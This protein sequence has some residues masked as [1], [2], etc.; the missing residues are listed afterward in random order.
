[1]KY[2]K[3][4]I[5]C[6]IVGF[7]MGI[8]LFRAYENSDTLIPVLKTGE[9][10]IFIKIG[11]YENT[12][13]MENELKNFENYVY[14]QNENDYS[15]YI[16]ITKETENIKKIKDFYNALGYITSEEEFLV[17]EEKFIEILNVYDKMLKD[18]T[19]NEVIKGIIMETLSKYEEITL[20]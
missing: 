15:A 11:T 18:A 8:F 16:G 4:I 13:I 1:M 14:K 20:K 7:F 6:I 10:V 3:P 12:T 2:I 5:L 9:N 17:K 19:N